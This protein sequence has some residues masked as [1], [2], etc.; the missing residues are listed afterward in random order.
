VETDR[1][2]REAPAREPDAVDRA[3][4]A[5]V[6]GLVN[7]GDTLQVGVGA[8]PNAIL[9]ALSGHDDL[10]V[11][12]GMITDGVLDLVQAGA[13]TG[14]KKEVDP[15]LVV[16][17]AALGSGTMYGKLAELPVEFRPASYTHHPAVLASFRSLV[18]IN[19]AIQ[20]DLLG[21]VGA[22]LGGGA[23]VGAVGGQAD[24]SRAASLTGTRSVI[25]LRSESRAGSAIVPALA[26]GVVTTAR[27]D[28]DAVVTEHGVALLTGCATEERARRLIAVAAPRYRDALERS[29]REQEVAP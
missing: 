12:T 4:G 9:A 14:A 10:G 5:L 11:H 13:V 15:G 28:V 19:S 29:L 2:L 26:G 8:L 16:T 17:G 1:P 6:A 27:A 20:V 25:A 7:D 24:F 23:H 21:Q 22:E 3:I 18:A